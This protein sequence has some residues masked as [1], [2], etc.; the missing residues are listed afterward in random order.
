MGNGRLK[1]IALFLYF[2]LR[3]IERVIN[4]KNRDRNEILF[5]HKLTGQRQTYKGKM[6][7]RKC[8]DFLYACFS[9]RLSP[10]L[11]KDRRITKILSDNISQFSR[12]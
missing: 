4:I 12:F 10:R 2:S 1:V 3:F 7:D 8:P 5:A 6:F 11:N 9:F